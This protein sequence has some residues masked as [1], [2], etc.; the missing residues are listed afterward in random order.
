MAFPKF[1]PVDAGNL[2][3]I[4]LV[5][6]LSLALRAGGAL[7]GGD[8]GVG[9]ILVATSHQGFVS[10]TIRLAHATFADPRVTS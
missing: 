3:M 7:R 9:R 2:R 6:R 10:V 8:G 5:E 4:R 1:R